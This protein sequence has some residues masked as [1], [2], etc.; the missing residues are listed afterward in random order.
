[1]HTGTIANRLFYWSGTNGPNGISPA[2][3]SRVKIAAL[4]TQP[5]LAGHC[6]WRLPN[7]R[8]L[9]SLVAVEWAAPAVD[10]YQDALSKI[11]NKDPMVRRQAAATLEDANA[12]LAWHLPRHNR[13][14]AVPAAEPDAAWRPWPDGPPP[15]AVFCFEYT[16]R[17]ERDATIGWDGGALS[18]PRRTGGASWGRRPVTVQERLDGSLWV[19]DGDDLYPLSPAPPS[20]PVLRRASSG[21]SLGFSR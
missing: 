8:E 18:L 6:D 2:D 14:F 21:R 4:N 20:T 15:E 17:V 5:C 10:P 16:R 9:D 19:R 12:L 1:M 13:R 7:R 11:K 3:G